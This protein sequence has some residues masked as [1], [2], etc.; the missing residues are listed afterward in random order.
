VVHGILGW[1]KMPEIVTLSEALAEE[2][3]VLAIDARGHGDDPSRFTWGREEWRQVGAAARW[4]TDRGHSRVAAVG[5][6]YGGFHC[7]RAA[8]RGAPLDRLLLVGA[9]A[10]LGMLEPIPLGPDFWRHVPAMLRRRRR[11]TRFERPP[12]LSRVAQDP[13]DLAA[14]RV[15]TLVIHGGADWLVRRRHAERY[16][17]SIPTARLVEFPGGL[18]AEYLIDSHREELLRTVGEFLQ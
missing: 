15:P 5:F 13:D 9:P 2:H 11:L 1:R 10:D 6:S 18:H 8:G 12:R 14:I 3:D 17:A 4:L 16:A 7:A